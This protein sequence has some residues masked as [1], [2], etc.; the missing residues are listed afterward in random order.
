[1][2]KL[3][4]LFILFTYTHS[5]VNAQNIDSKV[6][7]AANTF[8]A[9]GP[10]VG[11]SVGIIKNNQVYQYHF[12]STQKN[13]ND[14]P[15]DQT[16]YEVGSV[17]KTFISLLLAQAVIEKRVNLSDDI[18]KYL[19][20]NYPNLQYHG[21]PIQ[22]VHLAN[23]SS[24]LPDNFPEKSPAPKTMSPDSQ[25][26]ESK[27]FYDAFTRNQFLTELHTVK[28]TQ[29]PGSNSA[30]SNTAAQLLGLLLENIYGT[31]YDALLAKYITGPLKMGSTFFT[32]PT[33]KQ[34]LYARGYNEKGI[35]IPDI[36]KNAGSAAGLKSSLADMMVYMKYQ[37]EEKNEVVTMIHK[38][39]W[40][41]PESTAVG[42]VWYTKTNFDGK[43]DIWESGS[44][45]GH[46]CLIDM[47]PERNFGIVI[48]T[49]ESDRES[50][51]RITD[52][53]ETIYNELYFTAAQRS[54]EGF[55]FSA[56]ANILLDTLNKYG[57]QNA[58]KVAA[59]LK[60]QDHSFKLIE[61]EMNVLGY[62]FLNKGQ[63]EKAL[64]LFKLNVNLYPASSNAYDSLAEIYE[65]T[66]DKALAIK[67][68]KRALELDPKNSHS[69]EQLKRL[70]KE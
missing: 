24:G 13:T 9:S 63:K 27:K 19:H 65:S 35:L 66:G 41:K 14:T 38:P 7:H 62:K 33:A 60:K 26:L 52:M 43:K 8:M 18:R 57:F 6:Q 50:Q 48:L 36:P 10:R 11:L 51:D 61:D 30:H 34:A 64:E 46:S 22:L 2:K 49:N 39:T 59:D 55:G 53:A 21:K 40:G 16:I 68:Y 20:G 32:V 47:Y 12:G 1:M 28:L 3:F 5:L 31:S 25:P 45:G 37:L 42:L 15:T 44:T 54:K 4:L 23:L 67:N 70:K 17:T 56:A 58:I 69:A 29:E